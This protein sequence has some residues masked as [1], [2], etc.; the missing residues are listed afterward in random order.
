MPCTSDS[1]PNPSIVLGFFGESFFKDGESTWVALHAHLLAE[2]VTSGPT[3]LDVFGD[4]WE[5]F[6]KVAEGK[7]VGVI[8]RKNETF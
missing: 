1:Q 4:L 7:W 2:H 8:L 6:H 3:H 5:F